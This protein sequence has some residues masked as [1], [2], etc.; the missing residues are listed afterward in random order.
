MQQQEF[1]Y[2]T[3][4]LMP[5]TSFKW[6]EHPCC[7]V[8]CPFLSN[9]GQ[10]LP[11]RLV[12]RLL[13]WEN[14]DPLPW[15]RRVVRPADLQVLGK[16]LREALRPCWSTLE[17]NP[18]GQELYLTE[19]EMDFGFPI[20]AP[21]SCIWICQTSRDFAFRLEQARCFSWVSLLPVATVATQGHWMGRLQSENAESLKVVELQ[22]S[23]DWF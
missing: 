9:L 18:E 10:R 3:C 16:A 15:H 8:S 23:F 17:T 21:M 4:V 6:R 1:L 14:R 20:L 13:S 12:P 5:S 7:D 11:G 22:A 2:A 19:F